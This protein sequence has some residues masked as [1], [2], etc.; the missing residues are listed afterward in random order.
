M[1]CIVFKSNRNVHYT[2]N[3]QSIY[4]GHSKH[5]YDPTSSIIQIALLLLVP[6]ILGQLLR[7]Y[8]FPLMAKVPSIVKA[9]DQGTILM[10][11]YS[12]FSSAVIA[13]LWHQ[14]GIGTLIALIISCSVLLTIIMLSAFYISR[15]LGFNREDQISIFS[16][17]PKN[18]GQ[19]CTYGADLIHWSAAR[20]DCIADY[21][22]PSNS[23]H[24]LWNYRELFGQA[25]I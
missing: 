5:D 4:F 14:V 12:A 10:V 18:F 25:A 11:V 9:F 17:A 8:V 3:G 1:Q 6:F 20:Y 22:F 2:C 13:G 24:D 7:P 15:L 16:V 19:W 21:D 23:A